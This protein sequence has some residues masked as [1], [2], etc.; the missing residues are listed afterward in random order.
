MRAADGARCCPATTTRA[1]AAHGPSVSGG[2]GGGGGGGA[3]AGGLQWGGKKERGKSRKTGATERDQDF[4]KTFSV[5]KSWMREAILGTESLC[6][7]VWLEGCFMCSAP[8]CVRV[9]LLSVAVVVE[10]HKVVYDSKRVDFR[11]EGA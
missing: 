2:G 3:V 4:A 10:Y 7:Y 6:M 11:P 9:C 8:P 5:I 1:G